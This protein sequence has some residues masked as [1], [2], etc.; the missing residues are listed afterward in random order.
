MPELDN[1]EWWVKSMPNFLAHPHFS[2][3]P[4][5]FIIV[6]CTIPITLQSQVPYITPVKL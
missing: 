4:I 5:I 2:K 6:G 1:Q 3:P